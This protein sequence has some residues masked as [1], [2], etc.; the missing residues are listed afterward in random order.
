MSSTEVLSAA[1]TVMWVFE[2]FSFIMKNS[3]SV[4]ESDFYTKLKKLDVHEGKKGRL[5]ADQVIQV[6]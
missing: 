4:A 6:H 5:S 3:R 1:L 2:Q